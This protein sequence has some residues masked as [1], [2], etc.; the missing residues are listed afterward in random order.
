VS[1]QVLE[2]PARAACLP[3]EQRFSRDVHG[4]LGLPFDAIG[5]DEAVERM[6]AAAFSNTRCFVST[7]NLN[8]VVAARSDPSFRDSVLRS[9]LCLAD[10]APIVWM[11]RQHGVPIRER[12]AG[13]SVF[14]RL[15]AHPGPPITVYFF[16]GTP[17]V[18]RAAAAA[19]NATPGGLRC[20]GF[21]EAGFGSLDDMSSPARIARIN[22]SGAHF[23]VVALGAKKGQAWIERNA[24]NLQA[25]LLCH[26]G[27]VVNFVAGTVRRAP[28]WLQAAGLEWLWRIK[29]EPGL[30]RRYWDDGTVFAGMIVKELLR[31]RAKAERAGPAARPLI[32][33]KPVMG[34]VA[35]IRLSGDWTRDSL[36]PLR[37]ALADAMRQGA[38]VELAVRDVTRVDSAF[39][40]VVLLARGHLG[41]EGLRLVDVPAPVASTLARCGVGYLTAGAP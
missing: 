5:V 20:V 12:V 24:E 8:F 11:A 30:W 31:P 29:E 23:I 41:H 17:G 35:R 21:D 25:P 9:D 27:A 40:G 32:E 28:A 4:L 33:A 1:A 22:Q 34:G 10:G 16:G 39:V 37:A 15:R 2:L 13:A 19:L 26:L 6:R 3:N 38:E 14:E 36:A 7:P 18:A